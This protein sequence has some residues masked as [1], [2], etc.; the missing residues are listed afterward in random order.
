MKS[1][2]TQE[3]LIIGPVDFRSPGSITR[4]RAVSVVECAL[5]MWHHAHIQGLSSIAPVLRMSHS[6]VQVTRLAEWRSCS[7]DFVGT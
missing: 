5:P 2:K 7:R 4:T 3:S 1:K 6:L